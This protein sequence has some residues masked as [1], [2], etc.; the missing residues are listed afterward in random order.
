MCELIQLR[1]S[2]KFWQRILHLE[3]SES[4]SFVL[5]CFGLLFPVTKARQVEV[6]TCCVILA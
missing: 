3:L 5:V 2:Q 4:L 1:I 6:G